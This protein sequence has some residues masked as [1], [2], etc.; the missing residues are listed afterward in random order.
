MSIIQF[1]R[2][3]HHTADN[4]IIWGKDRAEHDVNLRALLERLRSLGMTVGV[5]SVKKMGKKELNFFGLKVS[6]AGI[7]IGDEKAEALLNA[8]RPGTQSE[9]HSFLGLAVYCMIPNLATLAE[10]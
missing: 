1:H 4:L 6:P 9:L 3:S 2:S 5:D 10:P 7:T 8:A